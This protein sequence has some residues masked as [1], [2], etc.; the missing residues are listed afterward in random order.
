MQE[1][2]DCLFGLPAA[3]GEAGGGE[4]GKERRKAMVGGKSRSPVSLWIMEDKQ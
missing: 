3:A 1:L 4:G 2:G